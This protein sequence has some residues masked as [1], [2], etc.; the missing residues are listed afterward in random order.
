MKTNILEQVPVD[1]SA[2]M[3]IQQHMIASLAKCQGVAVNLWV[4]CLFL[5][6]DPEPCPPFAADRSRPFGF[7]LCVLG[8]P[9]IIEFAGLLDRDAIACCRKSRHDSSVSE[10]QTLG[11]LSSQ[12]KDG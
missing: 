9:M 1:E 5:E 4:W 8:P 2:S 6:K 3:S 7:Y 10:V 12:V 11:C